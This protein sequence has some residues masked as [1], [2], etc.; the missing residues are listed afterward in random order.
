MLASPSTIPAMVEEDIM[1]T[2]RYLLL[3]GMLVGLISAD[4]SA[5]VAATTP[6]PAQHVSEPGPNQAQVA[7]SDAVITIHG[8]CE[9]GKQPGTDGTACRT[10]VTRAEFE[11]LINSM[12]VVGKTLSAQTRRSL[13]ETY[14]QYLAYEQPAKSAGLEASQRFA[15]IMRWWRLKTLAD[16]YIGSLQEQFKN[17]SPEEI[18]TYY[19]AHLSAYQRIKASRILVP[20]SIGD[21]DEAKLEDKKAF[22]VANSA[23]E[24]AAKGEDVASVQKDAYSALGL[25]SPPLTDLGTNPQS[26]FPQEERDELFS[27]EPGQVSKVE[28][29]GASYVIYK[30]VSNETVPEESVKDEISKKVAQDKYDDAVRSLMKS[31]NSDL[32]NA[33]FGPPSTQAPPHA[34]PLF[35]PRP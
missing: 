16:L 31:A 13:A 32:N 24:R 11:K 30:I 10:I 7:A 27:L 4:A 20:R 8:R 19:V 22:E 15:D 14:A 21:T 6:S 12:N 9:A 29:E 28:T 17:P 33:Y 35:S 18:H 2:L 23:R 3:T 25:S 34:E 5:Q 1:K 26:K